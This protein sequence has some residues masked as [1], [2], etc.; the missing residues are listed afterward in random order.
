MPKAR[1]RAA[2]ANI[3][4]HEFK[5][6]FFLKFEFQEI[7]FRKLK[8]MKCYLFPYSLTRLITLSSAA[9]ASKCQKRVAVP[10]VPVSAEGDK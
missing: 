7:Y 6:N 9:G 2:D 8:W 10:Q 1:S 5:F 3:R 4:T